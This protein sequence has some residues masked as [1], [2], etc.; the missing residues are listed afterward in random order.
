MEIDIYGNIY[1]L[2]FPNKFKAWLFRRLF[3][4]RVEQVSQL[5]P[6]AWIVMR[7]DKGEV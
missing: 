7:E 2:H 3:K 6:C 1:T 4:L 5:G